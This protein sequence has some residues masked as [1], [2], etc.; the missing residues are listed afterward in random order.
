[1]TDIAFHFNVPDKL[2][3]SCRLLRKAYLS[4]ARVAVTAEAEVLAE[5]DAL[6]WSFSATEFVPHCTASAPPA[7][8]AATPVVL[9][10]SLADLANR[11]ILVNLGHGVPG[12]YEGFERF[13][14]LVSLRPEDVQSGR[15][16]W[17]HYAAHGYI[18]KRH[19]LS[20]KSA[21]V[22]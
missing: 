21:G 2:A 15:D 17:K 9:S 14:E 1:M 22:A 16:R 6:L 12:G 10:V 19:D 11:E 20:S 5:L 18:L 3:Y 4:G 7:T 13:I 8:L